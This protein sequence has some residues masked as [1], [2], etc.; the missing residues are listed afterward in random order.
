MSSNTSNPILSFTRPRSAT[1]PH[2]NGPHRYT[3]RA[4]IEQAFG[5]KC[6]SF[7]VTIV[8][9]FSHSLPP[10]PGELAF[11]VWR[12]FKAQPRFFR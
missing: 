3:R 9:G 2:G 10:I 7:G 11:G 1:P 12:L 8:D 6:W 4:A 5:T